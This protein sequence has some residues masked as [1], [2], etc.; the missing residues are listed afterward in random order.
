VGERPS[1][2][3][4]AETDDDLAP[5]EWP[6]TPVVQVPQVTV[7]SPSPTGATPEKKKGILQ[8]MIQPF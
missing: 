5:D 1:L 8:R 2:A 7:T 3:I 4:D 6:R